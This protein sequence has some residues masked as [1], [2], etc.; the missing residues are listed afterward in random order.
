VSARVVLLGLVAALLIS[1][2]AA[3]LPAAA[4]AAPVADPDWVILVRHAEKAGEEGDPSL[5][6]AG[7][8]R[9]RVLAALLADTG[10]D[11]IYTTTWK[12]NRETA[13][14]VETAT[15]LRALALSTNQGADAHVVELI[16]RLRG[17]RHAGQK[18]LCVEH[19]N[20]IPLLLGKLGVAEVPEAAEYSQLFLITFDAGTPR[21]LVLRYGAPERVDAPR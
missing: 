1:P 5:T 19:S 6:E 10:L 4:A 7:R 20:T 11:A 17:G 21:V 16:Q 13:A 12:R 15:G 9:A 14:P 8:E 2:A 3:F 18:V